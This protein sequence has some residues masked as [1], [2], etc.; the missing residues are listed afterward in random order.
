[1][2]RHVCTNFR[3]LFRACWVTC[4]SYAMVEKILRYTLLC[5]CYLE[6]WHAPI[7]NSAGTEELPEYDTHVSK[8]VGVAE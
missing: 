5:V 7:G 4:E 1:M 2:F 3:E 8:H 6:A